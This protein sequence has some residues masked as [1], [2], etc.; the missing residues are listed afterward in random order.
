MGRERAVLRAFLIAGALTAVGLAFPLAAGSPQ[1]T[2]LP[3][4]P[5]S[6]EGDA[7]LPP[8]HGVVSGN[9]T[10]AN[11]FV[12][13]GWDIEAGSGI[14]VYVQDTGAIFVIRDCHIRSTNFG[15]DFWNV[16]RGRIE[17]NS[18]NASGT[19]VELDESNHLLIRNNNFTG[20]GL[21]LATYNSRNITLF[22]NSFAAGGLIVE[23]ASRDRY[24]PRIVSSHK[25]APGRPSK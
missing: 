1:A 3:H 10:A 4:E 15:I 19:G 7:Q 12:I 18:I 11:P 13:E 14:G 23:G 24:C 22:A 17:N 9:G 21:G 2:R 8:G 5:L 16:A 20:T 25:T 6:I